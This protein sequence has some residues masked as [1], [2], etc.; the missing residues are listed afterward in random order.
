MIF[1]AS[2]AVEPASRVPATVQIARSRYEVWPPEATDVSATHGQLIAVPLYDGT[3]V[4]GP[5]KDVLRYVA[6][7]SGPALERIRT[8]AGAAASHRLALFRVI[9]HKGDDAT[10]LVRL[11]LPELQERCTSCRTVHFFLHVR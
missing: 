9:G 11:R 7:V 6:T 5:P 1:C 2:P 8:R 10:L 4:A 3:L